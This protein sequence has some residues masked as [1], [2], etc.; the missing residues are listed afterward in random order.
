MKKVFVCV[1]ALLSAVPLM[2]QRGFVPDASYYGSNY[3]APDTL[4]DVR[5]VVS[6]AVPSDYVKAFIPWRRRDKAPEQKSLVIMDADNNVVNDVLPLTINKEYGEVLFKAPKAGRYVVYYLPYHTSGGPYPKVTYPKYP[7]R[8]EAAWREQ[9][10]RLAAKIAK[11]KAKDVA[12]ASFLKFESLGDFNSFYPMEITATSEEKRQLTDKNADKPFLLFPEDRKYPIR[13]F[14]NVAYRQYAEGASGSFYGEAT[15]NEYYVFQLGLWAFKGDVK[16]V[17]V[18]FS[19]LVN[20][21][22][23]KI[24]ADSM[25]CFN[26]QGVDWE[27][28]PQ[29]FNV[30]VSKGR[31]QP[32]WLGVQMPGHATA[33]LYKGTVT[34]QDASGREQKVGVSI[35]L[36]DNYLVDKGDKDLWRLSRLRWLNSQLQA[37]DALVKPYTPMTLE[38]HTVGVLGR[39]LTTDALGLPQAIRSYFTEEMTSIGKTPL[40]ILA[41]PMAFRI[42]Q[43]GHELPLDVVSPAHFRKLDDGAVV[44]SSQ[45]RAGDLSLTLNARMEFDGYVSYNIKVKAENATSVDDIALLTP[46]NPAVAKYRLGMGFEGS[47]RPAEGHWK[48]DVKKNQEGFWFGTVNGGMQCLFRDTNYRRPLNTNFYQMQPLNLPP[49]WYNEGKGGIDY[50]EAD[51][52]LRVSTYSGARSL[53]AGE[54]LNFNFLTFITPFRPIDTEK[55]W[56]DRYFHGYLPAEQVRKVKAGSDENAYHSA[57]VVTEMGANVINLH[58]GNAVNPHINYPFFRPDFMK[59]YID[60]AHEKN[61]RVKIY[62][63]V[64]ELT[65]WT[66][67]LFALKSLGHEIFSPGKGGG[68]AWL[69]EHFGDDYIAGWFVNAYKDAAIVNAGIS[70]W[71]NFYV[72][73]LNWLAKNVGIDGVYIDD[74]AFDRTTMKRIRRVLDANRPNALIDVHSC[75]QFDEADGYINSAFLYMEHFP[76]LDRLWFGENFKY[77]KGP[78]YWLTDVSGIPFGLM[79][80]MLQDGGNPYR[81]MLYG[82]TAREP[83]NP[84]PARLWKAWDQFGIKGCRMMG[85]WVSYNPVKTN[86][87]DVLATSYIRKGKVMIALA[88]WAGTDK[89]VRLQMDWKQLGLN[90]KTAKLKAT[91]IEGFQ[92]EQTLNPAD[93]I[94][95][96][97]GKGYLLVLE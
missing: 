63:T 5:A 91:A 42:V 27:G 87:D 11:G 95:V 12:E 61:Q 79:S 8:S 19:D 41:K 47:R 23:D 9:A 76:F 70:R 7:D 3:W 67:E 44:W 80:E 84:M 25:T 30:D 16:G 33:G 1:M 88:S 66:P 86:T 40:E 92:T 2:A 48:W 96:P 4:G 57:D 82:M 93:D 14:D 51:G 75:N 34:V 64:R 15:L 17:K 81:G 36:S 58:H 60:G 71:H 65:N 46:M 31:M 50:K 62:Y 28:K 68:Y 39:T 38:G 37:N 10:E 74:L 90:P 22:G 32:L 24:P 89:K 35:L 26:T 18:A 29:Q 73:G 77:E 43:N 54:E 59:Q 56:N 55:Q 52:V 78:D 45:A 13:M 85:Y 49:S 21:K 94:T 97:K 20:D 69:Q 6:V 72:E 53:K 83:S